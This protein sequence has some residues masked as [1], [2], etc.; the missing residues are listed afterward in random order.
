MV[1]K[2]P[3]RETDEISIRKAVEKYANLA[4]RSAYWMEVNLPGVHRIFF[5][6]SEPEEVEG[7][8]L[9]KTD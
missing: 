5:S 9:I 8:Q 7:F 2:V 1:F 3:E 6:E 4:F